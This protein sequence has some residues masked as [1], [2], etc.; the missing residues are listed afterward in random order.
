MNFFEI[1]FIRECKN[2]VFSE[3]SAQSTIKKIKGNRKM[4]KQI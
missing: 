1:F 4:F 2:Y 3:N